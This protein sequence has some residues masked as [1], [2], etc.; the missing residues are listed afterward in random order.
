MICSIRRKI[1]KYFLCPLRI[2]CL[3][4]SSHF[5]AAFHLGPQ[6]HGK[7]DASLAQIAIQ[8]NAVISAASDSV[9]EFTPSH[10]GGKIHSSLSFRR[11]T[12]HN[13]VPRPG[14]KHLSPVYRPATGKLCRDHCPVQIQSALV[15]RYLIPLNSSKIKADIPQYLIGMHTVRTARH[16]FVHQ[17]LRLGN[18][19]CIQVRPDFR[20]ILPKIRIDT[21]YLSPV[22]HTLLIQLNPLTVGT[23]VNH[24]TH[25]AV[26]YG[27]RLFPLYSR[28]RVPQ[29]SH[30][31]TSP[32]KNYSRNLKITLPPVS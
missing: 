23:A 18:L 10:S 1:E 29:F 28:L 6:K 19:P 25:S 3:S 24:C 21:V 30:L 27:K 31:L 14:G 26:S 9:K 8:L 4:Q 22:P 5:P 15:I 2:Q 12:H 17:P 16:G 32:S 13:A 11:K 7:I 20:Q